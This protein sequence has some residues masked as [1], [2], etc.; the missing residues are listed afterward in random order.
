M[1]I[2]ERIKARRL[3][4]GISQRILAK[5]VRE[6]GDLLDERQIS[7]YENGHR[8]PSI[9]TL[10]KISSVLDTPVSYLLGE[11]D[12]DDLTE[13]KRLITKSNRR[14]SAA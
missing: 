5:K 9:A 14:R 11:I 6:S 12:I 7:E 13:L 2:G 1:T 3:A 8:K 10:M 4:L